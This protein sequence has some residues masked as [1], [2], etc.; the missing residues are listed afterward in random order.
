VPCASQCRFAATLK[1]GTL[2]AFDVGQLEDMRAGEEAPR[3]IS[4]SGLPR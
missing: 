1:N 4:L 2:R 3:T